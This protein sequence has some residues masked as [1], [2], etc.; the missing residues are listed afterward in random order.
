M[1]TIDYQNFLGVANIN[2]GKNQ[3]KARVLDVD[4]NNSKALVETVDGSLRIKLN[5]KT[6]ELLSVGDYVVV[7]YDK[8]LTKKNA[9]ISLRNGQAVPATKVN[10]ENAI[11]IQEKVASY[12]LHEY[13][14]VDYIAGNKI[15][16]GGISNPIILNGYTAAKNVSGQ[17][18]SKDSDLYQEIQFANKIRLK[19]NSGYSYVYENA[20]IYLNL[21]YF[22]D[23]G[24]AN[25]TFK[26]DSG[27]SN[28]FKQT[29]TTKDIS[30]SGI[31]LVY[32][33]ISP[34]STSSSF[35]YGY[36]HCY[37]RIYYIDMNTSS[38]NWI[39]F[40][41]DYALVSFASE[42]EYNAAVGLTYEPITLTQINETKT[43]V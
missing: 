42:A 17:D 9:Y 8:V 33:N 28:Q 30:Q 22:N 27:T 16:Y 21:N 36:A 19:P 24:S 7:E 39:T 31:R 34:P 26:L 35:P 3:I 5:N 6:G 13:T 20:K 41:G 38:S 4:S 25:V 15:V 29:L 23:D 43:V 12:L 32:K 2:N 11:V 40:T 14:V 10:I 1:E 37:I 18:I